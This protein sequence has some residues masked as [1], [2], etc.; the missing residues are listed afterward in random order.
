MQRPVSRGGCATG[1]RGMLQEH[2][3]PTWSG[4]SIKAAGPGPATTGKSR[5]SG[6]GPAGYLCRSPTV[7]Q[8]R[9]PKKGPKPYNWSSCPRTSRCSLRAWAASASSCSAT[10][11]I[12]LQCTPRL[13]KSLQLQLT[14]RPLMHTPNS[15]TPV[16]PLLR[17]STQTSLSRRTTSSTDST[18]IAR[19]ARA[20]P[21]LASSTLRNTFLTCNASFST[22]RTGAPAA[23]SRARSGGAKIF[24]F[25]QFHDKDENNFAQRTLDQGRGGHSCRHA[26]VAG[27]APVQWEKRE[28]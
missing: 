18:R 14:C 13:R 6:P 25:P 12:C 2:Y 16:F 28:A 23:V 5:N 17:T 9:R 26:A 4:A 24:S 11:A 20:L 27:R 1:L 22:S 15:R 10:S 19:P 8:H 3:R 7:Y 21:N